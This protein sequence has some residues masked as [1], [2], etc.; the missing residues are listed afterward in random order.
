MEWEVIYREGYDGNL[1]THKLEAADFDSAYQQF[2]ALLAT[3][4]SPDCEELVAIMPSVMA[5]RLS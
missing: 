1:V 2:K 5:D 3:P 4:A